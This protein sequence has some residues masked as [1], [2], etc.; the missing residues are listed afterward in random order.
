MARLYELSADFERLFGEFERINN[1]EDELTP[2]EDGTY[3]DSDGNLIPDVVEYKDELLTAWFDTLDGIEG[4]IE[5]K[6]ENIAC[7]IKDLNAEAAAID[8]E[9]KRLKLRRDS[10]KKKAENLAGYLLKTMQAIGRKKITSPRAAITVSEGRDSVVVEDEQ[11][12]IDW[13]QK[14]EHD[15]LLKYKTPD[16]SKTAVKAALSEGRKIPFVHMEKKPSIGIK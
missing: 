1:I 16:I 2:G 13:A 10:A 14:G 11:A 15:E 3:T 12:L 9:M 8:S 5:A 4:E 6:A 7:F